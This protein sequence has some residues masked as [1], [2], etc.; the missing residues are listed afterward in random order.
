MLSQTN[1]LSWLLAYVL[2]LPKKNP[3]FFFNKKICQV[4]NYV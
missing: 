3:D 2:Y 4:L 1:K